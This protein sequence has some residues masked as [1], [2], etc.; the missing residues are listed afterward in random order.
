MILP[1]L[2]TVILSM[3]PPPGWCGRCRLPDCR[4]SPAG[5][6]CRRWPPKH[7]LA[8]AR[9]GGSEIVTGEVG[10]GSRQVDDAVIG[11]DLIVQVEVHA[12][13]DVHRGVGAEGVV[14]C[15]AN[16]GW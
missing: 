3:A 7:Y 16:Y 4:R 1:L 8:G 10:V 14:G 12:V 15:E 6:Y 13:L 5:S 11:E 2:V 9:Q